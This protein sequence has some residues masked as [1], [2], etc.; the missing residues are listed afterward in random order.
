MIEAIIAGGASVLVGALSLIG[1]VL[2]NSRANSKM[3][4]EMK[5]AQAVTDERLEEL[6]RE[7]RQ[8]NDFARRIPVIEEKL[9]VTNH[10]LSDLEDF[11]K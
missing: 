4:N 10:R 1:V 9:K 5:T 3:Q 11:H 8:H 2:T 7:V 6:T